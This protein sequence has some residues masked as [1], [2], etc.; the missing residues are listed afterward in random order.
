MKTIKR[1]LW[2][3]SVLVVVVGAG[4][5]ARPVSYFNGATYLWECLSSVESR[6]L[7]VA[8][9]HMHYLAEGPE[10]GPVVVLVH[11]LGGR[12]ENWRQL[13]PYLTKAGYRVY[14]PD[15]L[16]YGR[17][18]KP[19]GFSYSVHDEAEMVAGFLDAMGLKKVDLGGWSMG[20][21]IV[22][23][24]A[25]R[26][27]ERVRRLILFDSV[28]IN[29]P[30]KFDVGLFMPTTSAELDQRRALMMPDPPK[31]PGFI[32]TDILRNSRKNTWVIQ[33]AVDSMRTG[34]D[35]TDKLLP[36]LKMPV[37]IVWGEMDWI[38]PL[39]QGET[40]HRLVPQSELDVIHGCG[41][42]APSQCAAQI[43]PKVV[44]FLKQ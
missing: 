27:P 11:G 18:E 14:E 42:L 10:G 15:L 13:A 36:Q 8:G 39:E 4:F 32:A 31:V 34:Q 22:Q 33:R 16:G 25:I 2:A 29:Q 24:V 30:P 7:Q 19:A 9:H 21:A 37:L 28:G 43:G 40:M 26:H 41:H 17:S 1:L 38:I 23:H 5:W 20:G 3:V 6:S 44:E 35:A 12:A